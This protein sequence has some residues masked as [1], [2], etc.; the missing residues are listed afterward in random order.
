MAVTSQHKNRYRWL[1]GWWVI[2]VIGG[3]LVA[4]A[5]DADG[6]PNTDNLPQIALQT[7]APTEADIDVEVEAEHGGST[8]APRGF[9]LCHFAQRARAVREWM[10]RTVALPARGP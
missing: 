9:F 4:V 10:W 5:W 6:N 3:L 1:T 8:D 7:A 2:L